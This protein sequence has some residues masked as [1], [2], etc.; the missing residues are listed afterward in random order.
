MPQD[1]DGGG[2]RSPLWH[3]LQRMELAPPPPKDKGQ[4]YLPPREVS[5]EDLRPLRLEF[6]WR[7]TLILKA[8]GPSKENKEYLPRML[9]AA[10]VIQGVHRVLEMAERLIALNTVSIPRINEMVPD[11]ALAA[12]RG[13]LKDLRRRLNSARDELV[14]TRARASNDI[15][16]E[17]L[18]PDGLR[19]LDLIILSHQAETAIQAYEVARRRNVAGID[20]GMAVSSQIPPQ[21]YAED[22]FERLFGY[23]KLHNLL[24]FTPREYGRVVLVY[25]DGRLAYDPG[26]PTEDEESS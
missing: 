12:R 25:E 8:F 3:Y 14:T 23:G 6:D 16:T 7:P 5:S 10:A 17:P 11:D 21:D 20:F 9:V 2:K 15:E 22:W 18:H 1:D 26:A 13:V 19:L 24:L 4:E